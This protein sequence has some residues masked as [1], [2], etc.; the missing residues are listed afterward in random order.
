MNIIT[1]KMNIITLKGER[2]LVFSSEFPDG[3]VRTS[4]SYSSGGLDLSLTRFHDVKLVCLVGLEGAVGNM[5]LQLE[6]Y[7][8]C[9]KQY[10]H[11]SQLS[12]E[13]YRMPAPYIYSITPTTL[14]SIP[15]EHRTYLVR[16]LSEIAKQIDKPPID[17]YALY[18]QDIYRV[19]QERIPRVLRELAQ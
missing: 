13:T 15:S 17:P 7:E 1:L 18:D 10:P 19:F 14:G 3:E 4:M 12:V 6:H 9:H 11:A 16:G 2:F 8:E 5:I